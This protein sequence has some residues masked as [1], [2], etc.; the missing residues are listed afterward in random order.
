MPVFELGVVGEA[1]QR[2]E[3]TQLAVVLFG[4]TKL[5]QIVEALDCLLHGELQLEITD[6]SQRTGKYVAAMIPLP[7]IQMF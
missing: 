5:L 2:E 1:W 4:W 7:F 3:E 6:N